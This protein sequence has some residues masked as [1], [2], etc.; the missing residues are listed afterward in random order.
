MC[1]STAGLP[2]EQEYPEAQGRVTKKF[3]EG[4]VHPLVVLPPCLE[5]GFGIQGHRG[6][7]TTEVGMR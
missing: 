2:Q 6:D 5:N 1:S 3:A 4:F 7:S